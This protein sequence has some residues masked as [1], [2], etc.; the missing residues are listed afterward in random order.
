MARAA[1]PGFE[2]F[3]DVD[4]HSVDDNYTAGYDHSTDYD[5]SMLPHNDGLPK[6]SH[7]KSHDRAMRWYRRV[8][9]MGDAHHEFAT[10]YG[11]RA[12]EL[13]VLLVALNAVVSSAI[14]TSL[15]E[16]SY[17]AAV[18]FLA[19][20]LS[21]SVAVL[22]AIKSQLKYDELAEA[23]RNAQR[24]FEKVRHRMESASPRWRSRSNDCM[25]AARTQ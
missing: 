17:S 14:F 18:R 20:V 2:R 7:D 19:G 12:T 21:L 25:G 8:R 10:K 9:V 6:F 23:H 16:S 3:D 4:D 24:G 11:R 13:N 15:Q 22:T 5:G 1:S